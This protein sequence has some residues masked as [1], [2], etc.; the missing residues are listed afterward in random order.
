MF[1]HFFQFL[2]YYLKPFSPVIAVV[3]ICLLLEFIPSRNWTRLIVKSIFLMWIF[4]YLIYLSW[5]TITYLSFSDRVSAV[6]S[7]FFY[8]VEAFILLYLFL[9]FLLSIWSTAIRRS[10]ESDR[11]SQDV[12]S[13]R[14]LPSVD[15]FIPTYNEPEFIVRRTVVGCQ[16]I[17]YAN[18]KVYI[19]DDTR[20]TSFRDLAEELGCEYVTRPDNKHAKAGNLNN[21]LL[22]THGELIA[23]LDA[24]FVPFKS[25]LTRTVGFFQQ[26][27][28]ALV[29]TAQSFYNPDF[30]AR[31]L[32]IDYLL[33]SDMASIYEFDLTTN[34]LAKCSNCCGSSYV[35][36]RIALESVG[37]YETVTLQEDSSTSTKMIL[38]GF[39]TIYLKE[40]LS[41]GEAARTYADLIKQRTRWL[42][43]NYQIFSRGYS[44]PIWSK[45]NWVQKGYYFSWF[46]SIYTPFIRLMISIM[47]PLYLCLGIFSIDIYLSEEFYY[48][49]AF[50]IFF[51]GS[52]AWS[53]DYTTSYFQG[54]LYQTL[55][56]F[57]FLKSL[58]F[59]IRNPFG[60]SFKTRSKGVRSNNKKYNLN[61]TWPL[62]VG[63]YLALII[64]CLYLWKAHIG[65]IAISPNSG[66][67][68]FL[69]SSQ[70]VFMSIAVFAAIE[71]P[72]RRKMDRFSLCTPCKLQ[73]SNLPDNEGLSSQIYYGYTNDCSESGAK[74]TLETQIFSHVNKI[75]ILEF[76]DY[77]FSVEA[78]VTRKSLQSNNAEVALKF[79]RVDIQ[80]YRHLVEM[81]YTNIFWYQQRKRPRNTEV[82][83]ALLSSLLRLRPG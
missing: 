4:S 28:V 20:R 22:K 43:G 83:L 40:V 42:H 31:S 30:Y 72:E 82:F 79:F 78:Q 80:E 56:F 68:I 35:A 9:S 60:L 36:R 14:Y 51:I 65:E 57:P 12:V 48:F 64:L 76:L 7:L 58:C 37:G 38:S 5:H 34:D 59:A 11:Y 26:P 53:A 6:F 75:V 52:R 17:E 66:L 61:H 8:L 74:I 46:I 27:N 23:V 33:P 81:L 2:E 39:E 29:Q 71:L 50:Y 32:G 77:K 63:I 67:F 45:L 19:L 47:P 41:I 49:F 3:L 54:E 21:A 24:D 10:V 73:I 1:E 69:L 25:F 13:G 62:I 18:K 44:L 55:L 70:F 15:V 16:A